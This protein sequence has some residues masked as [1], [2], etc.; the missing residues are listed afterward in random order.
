MEY[1]IVLGNS[2]INII[3]K[4]V[5]TAINYFNQKPNS[6]YNEWTRETITTRIL[7]FSGG[8]SQTLKVV[9]SQYMKNYAISKGVKPDSIL[10]ET[11]SSST[12]ENL[13]NC[14]NIIDSRNS[15]ERIYNDTITIVTSSFHAKRSFVLSKIY[16]KNYPVTIIHTNEIVMPEQEMKE[17]VILNN[18]L[19]DYLGITSFRLN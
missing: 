8:Y 1:I 15:I 16:I 11:N 9:E 10:C 3:Q 18:F 14:C 5:D 2:N 13:Q 7:L 4:R 17:I 19:S 12:I 6:L